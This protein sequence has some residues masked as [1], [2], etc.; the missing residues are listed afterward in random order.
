MVSCSTTTVVGVGI[1]AGMMVIV[2]VTVVYT[3]YVTCSQIAEE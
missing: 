1:S 3:S 2:P